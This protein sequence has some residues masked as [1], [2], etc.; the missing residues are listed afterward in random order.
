MG[1]PSNGGRKSLEVSG[2]SSPKNSPKKHDLM[3][4]S[5]RDTI[6][7]KW[8]PA[9]RNAVSMTIRADDIYRQYARGQDP[10]QLF[11]KAANWIT[12]IQTTSLDED[13]TD[14][15]N[16]ELH[17]AMVRAIFGSNMIEHAGLGS[18]ITTLLC[19][20][21]FAGDDVGEISERG[22][23]CQNALLELYDKQADLKGR[24]SQYV[25]RG[26]NEIIQHAK[27]FQF[28][29]HAFVTEKQDL[30]EDLIKETHR[31]LTKGIP[32]CI[33]D[34]PDVSPEE[35]GGTYRTIVVGAGS[36]NFTV[37]KFV[38][39]KMEEM[40]ND[41][42]KELAAAEESNTVDPFSIAAKYSLE[43]VEIHPFQDGNGR[44]CRMILN[45]I[46]CRYAGIIVP[47]GEHEQERGEYMD[48][49]KRASQE[50]EG[51]GEYA[52]FVLR[53]SITR[54]REMKKK[55]AGKKKSPRSITI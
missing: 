54:L 24:H 38:P 7:K 35:Y 18:D 17:E 21:I 16:E 37:P 49:K 55:L 45:A 43:F 11:D 41:L 10:K 44:M 42:K 47:I 20:K 22:M 19:K 8:P 9:S 1:S 36:T 13:Q 28:I 26:R 53:R 48:I 15:L 5:L 12:K 50:M 40:C 27:A 34:G 46:L 39:A 30:T 2:S 31:I 23:S 51:H 33:P 25:L 52:L 32:I 14:L 4:H 3:K 6:S 29:I